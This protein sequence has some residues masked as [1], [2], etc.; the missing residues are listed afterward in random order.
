MQQLPTTI[1]CRRAND[2]SRFIYRSGFPNCY[3]A[4]IKIILNNLFRLQDLEIVNK[5]S[6]ALE[7]TALRAGIPEIM[8]IKYDRMRVNGKKGIAKVRNHI[9]TNCRI[10]VPIAVTASLMNGAESQVCGNCGRFLC[11]PDSSEIKLE[12]LAAL[13]ALPVTKPKLRRAKKTPKE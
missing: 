8:L 10:Q 2:S 1:E 7:I 3:R 11:L 9:C 6:G 13:A 12:E 5:P 4:S